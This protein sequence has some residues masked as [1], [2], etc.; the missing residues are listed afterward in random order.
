MVGS[1]G[2]GKSEKDLPVEVVVV[3][4]VRTGTETH[5]RVTQHTSVNAAIITPPYQLTQTCIHKHTYSHTHSRAN[6]ENINKILYYFSVN[7]KYSTNRHNVNRSNLV[8][9]K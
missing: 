4:L 6:R 2:E 9:Y 7:I 1:E 5:T 3:R 8:Q